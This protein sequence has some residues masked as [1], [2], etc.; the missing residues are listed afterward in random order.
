MPQ[1]SGRTWSRHAQPTARSGLR[2][3]RPLTRTG[4]VRPGAGGSDLPWTN[5]IGASGAPEGPE[6]LAVRHAVVGAVPVV[7]GSKFEGPRCAYCDRVL[8]SF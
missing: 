8:R 5:P 2:P 7:A 6:G 1:G 4:G 3:E